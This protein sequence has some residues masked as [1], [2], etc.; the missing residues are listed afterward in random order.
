MKPS[1]TF[2]HEGFFETNEAVIGT[3]GGV[4]EISSIT[5]LSPATFTKD[6]SSIEIDCV[7]IGLIEY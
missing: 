7:T 3:R 6:E 5:K 4:K 2:G 1:S